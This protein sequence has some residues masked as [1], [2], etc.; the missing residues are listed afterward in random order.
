[1]SLFSY[2]LTIIKEKNTGNNMIKRKTTEIKKKKN[3]L[4]NDIMKFYN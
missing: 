1:M 2:S 4:Q 3:E